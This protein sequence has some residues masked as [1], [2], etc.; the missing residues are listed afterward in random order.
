MERRAL[1]LALALTLPLVVYG[2]P[3]AYAAQ[4]STT[5][6]VDHQFD[7][8]PQSEVLASAVCHGG[9]YVTGGGVNTRNLIL[10]DL[11]PTSFTGQDPPVA[12][13][14][15]EI[16]PSTTHTNS[17]LVFAVCQT[18]IVVAGVTVPQFGSLYFAIA[19]GA[20]AYFM[21]SRRF[22]RKPTIS[23]S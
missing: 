5:Y 12:Y 3:Y 15:D 10:I 21:L 22:G 4:T 14:V 2:V 1:L 11:E 16:N 23:A 17:G 18:P 20:V 6:K 19:L 9:D 13:T 8:A 7:V